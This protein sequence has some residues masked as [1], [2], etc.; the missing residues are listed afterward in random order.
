VLLLKRDRV[1]LDSENLAVPFTSEG[2]AVVDE[3]VTVEDVNALTNGEISGSVVLLR[4]ERHAR[5]V[6]KK[7]LLCELL[8]LKKHWERNLAVVG[9]VDFLHFNGLIG[10]E[11][12]E[13]IV[14]VTTVIA[15]V[16]PKDVEREDLTVILEEAVEVL[17]WATSLEHDLD[18]V[19]VLSKIGRILLHRDHCASLGERIVG[20]A[21]S[22]IQS[23]S[24]V[25]VEP[26][27][28][29]I[30]IHNTENAAVDVEVDSDVKVAPSIGLW[31]ETRDQ[32][33]VAL[34]EDA[35]GNARVLNLVFEDVQG[36]VIEVVED[37]ALADAVVLVGA[38]NN[39][40]LEVA[41]E[42][43]DLFI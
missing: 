13:D 18:I 34:E 1:H 37:C 2:V 43:Q 9:L 30:S 28:E 41:F 26:A 10:Q 20:I 33:L 42:V 21:L 14:L 40:L 12:V 5:V 36:I 24:F 22:A 8:S 15:G 4:A 35:L 6:S 31:L 16:F 32:D 27:G 19:L 17:V 39:G 11:E 7:W 25:G 38:L 29:V 23:N 3:A